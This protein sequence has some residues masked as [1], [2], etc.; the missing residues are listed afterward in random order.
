MPASGPDIFR[1]FVVPIGTDSRTSG[2]ARWSSARARARSCT[3]RSSRYVRGGAYATID[4]AD[5]KPGFR[6]LCADRRESRRFAPAGRSAAG[7]WARRP[8][9]LPEGLAA[10]DGQR[11]R[12]RH[13]D[14]LPSRPARWRRERSTVGIYFADEAPERRLRE[15]A[16]AR[17]VRHRLA[18]SRFRPAR[19]NYVIERSATMPVDVRV[20]SANRTRIISARRSRR[21]PRCPTARRSRC[22]GSRT[23]TST[24]RIGYNYKQPVVLPKGTRI[25]VRITYDNSA[26]N[27]RNP[28]NPPTARLVGRAVDG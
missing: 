11:V 23:G 28:S 1:N 21:P 9:F 24:G 6:G 7:R 25:D 17:P 27:P 2:C 4:G 14:A 15:H 8:R 22:C 12:L 19:S 18:G 3:T 26:D 10:A 16:A 13:P 5:G 20:Y